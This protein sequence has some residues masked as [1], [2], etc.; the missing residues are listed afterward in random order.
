MDTVFISESE[1]ENGSVFDH[2]LFTFEIRNLYSMDEGKINKKLVY[3]LAFKKLDKVINVLEK[4][5]FALKKDNEF[6]KF[7][8]DHWVD[9]NKFERE[10]DNLRYK[11]LEEENSDLKNK[12]DNLN[13][14]N[15]KL[16]KMRI[17]PHTQDSQLS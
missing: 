12:L 17:C 16:L 14:E 10:R 11:K 15:Q 1:L 7:Q 2:R 8:R 6:E 5:V 3:V 4:Q 9:R 13:T